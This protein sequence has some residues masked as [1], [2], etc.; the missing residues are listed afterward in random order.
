MREPL[1]V[2]F[3]MDCERIASE[4]PP[5]GPATWELSER[6]IR[7]FCQ[8]LLNSGVPPTLFATP[9]CAQYH[10]EQLR[11]LAS[12]GVELGMH[13]HPQ[14]L[15]DHRYRQ[16]LGQYSHSM[17]REIIQRG[18]E[19]FSEALGMRPMSFRPGNFSA[20]DGTFAVLHALGFQKGSVSDPGRD[21]P[22]LA[23]VWKETCPDPHWAN[24]GN[25]LRS[26]DLSFLE[27]PVTTDPYRLHPNGF[28][29]ELR[30]ESGTFQDWHAPI[31]RQ[32][33]ER[34]AAEHVGFRCLCLFTH[35]YFEYGD[36]HADQARTVQ[37]IV[38]HLHA[39]QGEYR[40]IPATLATIRDRYV[41]TVTG[42]QAVHAPI[43]MDIK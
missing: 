28:P 20:S 6:A 16:Y 2:A 18:M 37:D 13:I 19:G 38:E 43:P 34:M 29:Y 17:Q 7:G 30:I 10:R 12:Q 15:G 35:N 36:E 9:E 8:L 27:V 3:T 22:Q 1:Y 41:E 21:A 24:E 40:V 11:D 23:A 31:M 26:G 14:S 39:L 5:G 42:P 25:R 33:L 4:S 32:A